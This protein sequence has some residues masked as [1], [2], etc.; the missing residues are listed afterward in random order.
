MEGVAQRQDAIG[1]GL[2]AVQARELE[3]GLV[4]LG[5]RVAEVDP[6]RLPRAGEAL[7]PR[8]ELELRRGREVVR[9]VSEGRGLSRDGL[10]ENGMRVA[11]SIH[12]DSRQEVE[13]THA[14]AVP[15]VRTLAA[16]EEREPIRRIAHEIPCR[17]VLPRHDATTSVPIP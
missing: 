11:Q 2:L 10:D 1:A 17:I 16:H 7:Q 12:R 8:G 6:A 14:V 13:V 5:A 15:Q 9:D 4:R 3:G